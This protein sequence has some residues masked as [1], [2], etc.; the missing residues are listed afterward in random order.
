MGGGSF[1][2]AVEHYPPI[3]GAERSVAVGFPVV[4]GH[5][6]PALEAAVAASDRLLVNI[7]RTKD[8][9]SK[10]GGEDVETLHSG[11]NSFLFHAAKQHFDF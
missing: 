11:A 6:Q 1:A 9:E 4:P 7:A 8:G 10:G 2:G 5:D 3:L